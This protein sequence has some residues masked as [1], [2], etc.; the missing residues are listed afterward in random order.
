MIHLEKITRGNW[1]EATFVSTDPQHKCPLDE[2][3]V[4]STAFSIVQSVYETEWES[5]LILDGETIIG[6]VFY[7]IWDVKNAPLLCRYMIDIDHQGKGYGQA[8]LPVVVEEIQRQ[9]G[10]TGIYLTLEKENRR[11]VHIYEKFGF[12]P[13]GE[14]D[15]GEDI[16]Y[17]A[18]E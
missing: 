17:L 15:E 7:G 13:T 3:W 11:A 8:A 1:R 14:T 2:E 16:Y 12:R 9:Y 6:F 4:C 18:L 10:C 5:R